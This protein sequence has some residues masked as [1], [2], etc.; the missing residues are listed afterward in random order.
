MDKSEDQTATSVEVAIID[1]VAKSE[2]T[3]FAADIGEVAFDA[4]LD[5]GLLHDIPVV[6]S[7]AKLF[8]AG[9]SIKERIFVRKVALFLNE[10]ADVD[11]SERQRF[12][13]KLDQDEGSRQRAGASLTLLLDRLDD[14]DKPSIVG[15]LYRANLEERLSFGELR[16]FCMIVDRAHLPDL[17]ALT[18]LPAGERVD[19]IS[20]RYL[21]ALGVVTITGEDYGTVDAIGAETWY[22]VNEL[23]K[24]FLSIAF[25]D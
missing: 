19:S 3:G 24:S 23:G 16:R 15:R 25:V 10:I 7:V 14:L 20:A 1:S 5:D 2:L 17:V 22:E 4:L 8:R 12:A 11:V 21:H 9:A 6:G 18:R 13:A